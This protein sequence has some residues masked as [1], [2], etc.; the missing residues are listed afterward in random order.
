[1]RIL[2]SFVALTLLCSSTAHAERWAL[3]DMEVPVVEPE[4]SLRELY[5]CALALSSPQLQPRNSRVLW[6]VS[7]PQGE[8]FQAIDA[9][10]ARLPVEDSSNL[11]TVTPNKVFY[12]P[13]APAKSPN[14]NIDST[15][16][17]KTP[18]ISLASAEEIQKT[19]S[20]TGD[21]A[22]SAMKNLK[23][24]LKERLNQLPEIVEIHY[25][26]LH[27][28]MFEKNNIHQFIFEDSL[29]DPGQG[30][31][32]K[33]DLREVREAICAC[34]RV[35]KNSSTALIERL[36]GPKAKIIIWSPRERRS[37]P[38]YKSDLSCS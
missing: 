17:L 8:V 20:L 13:V 2:F 28:L 35:F 3:P 24:L 36:A 38:I 9:I 33:A 14:E 5:A 34:D 1:M 4:P 6:P 32:N 10:K 31:L 7:V 30:F 29:M 19:D 26:A 12:N 21:E 15:L 22:Q 23:L 25:Q 11:L 16:F 18:D 37:R 27:S